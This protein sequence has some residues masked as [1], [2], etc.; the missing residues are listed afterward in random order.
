MPC[1]LLPA[2]TQGAALLPALHHTSRMQPPGAELCQTPLTQLDGDDGA[3][4][5]GAE[6]TDHLVA[7][8]SGGLGRLGGLR[9][10]ILGAAAARGGEA[11]TQAADGVAVHCRLQQLLGFAP[12]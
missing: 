12:L 4:L 7:G 5:G 6:I 8:G 1:L 9:V 3:M 11:A 2:L 10:G